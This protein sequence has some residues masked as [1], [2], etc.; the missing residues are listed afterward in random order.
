MIY[1]GQGIDKMVNMYKKSFQV[2][3][4]KRVYCII[5][6]ELLLLFIIIY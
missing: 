5:A 4:N 6:G 1:R 3:S 2:I